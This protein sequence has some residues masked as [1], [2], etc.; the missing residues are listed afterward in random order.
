MNYLE[1]KKRV[2]IY[3][4]ARG[5][6]VD[7]I[8]EA[9]EFYLYSKFKGVD[10]K[11]L[12]A[13]L[14]IALPIGISAKKAVD[15]LAL[16]LETHLRL[17]IGDEIKAAE[18]RAMVA[19]GLEFTTLA[20][21]FESLALDSLT[22]ATDQV[23]TL[24]AAELQTVAYNRKADVAKLEI[25]DSELGLVA[26]AYLTTSGYATM[27]LLAL[28]AARAL[29]T[30]IEPMPTTGFVEL[31]DKLTVGLALSETFMEELASEL[32][33][34][35]DSAIDLEV[36]SLEPLEPDTM[37]VQLPGDSIA[38]KAELIQMAPAEANVDTRFRLGVKAVCV[39]KA[40][41]AD[42]AGVTVASLEG[43]FIESLTYIET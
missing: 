32:G 8:P 30:A 22:M 7:V 38:V 23:R 33:I 35:L 39:K 19:T 37:T 34:D 43:H 4:V 40:V 6:P 10:A 27:S 1:W 28:A 29:V 3:M 13:Q 18:P 12:P 17:Q 26:T 16:A 42:Y 14:A 20:A 41:V 2:L 11:S 24:V 36:E 15:C 9:L 25:T 5:K 21:D 31:G